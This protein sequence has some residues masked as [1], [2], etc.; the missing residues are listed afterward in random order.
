VGQY[1][2]ARLTRGDNIIRRMHYPCQITKVA[3]T[4]SDYIFRFHGKTDF[5]KAPQYYVYTYIACLFLTYIR[6]N[7]RVLSVA[8]S[9]S[10]FPMYVCSKLF[11]K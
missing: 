8:D 4:H 11:P 1:G 7:I 3:D 10:R 2:G 6:H 9:D 5:A